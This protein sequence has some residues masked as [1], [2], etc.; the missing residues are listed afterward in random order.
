M[1]TLLQFIRDN[2]ARCLIV[3]GI[4]L[5]LTLIAAIHRVVEADPDA[6]VFSSGIVRTPEERQHEEAMRLHDQRER[7]HEVADRRRHEEAMRIYYK[8]EER[9]RKD[10]ENLR[11]AAKIVDEERATRP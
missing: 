6:D 5:F 11:K 8:R 7:E 10:I 1:R 4:A 2:A 3:I 9:R